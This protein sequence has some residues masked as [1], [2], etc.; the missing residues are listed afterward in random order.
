MINLLLKANFFCTQ[1]QK[2]V[3]IPETK[4]KII[5]LISTIFIQLGQVCQLVVLHKSCIFCVFPVCYCLVIL[6]RWSESC[7]AVCPSFL[8]KLGHHNTNIAVRSWWVTGS[9]SVQYMAGF[10]VA[11]I[12][13][14]VLLFHYPFCICA[15]GVWSHRSS[16]VHGHGGAV[17]FPHRKRVMGSI[18]GIYMFQVLQLPPTIQKRAGHSNAAFPQV[19]LGSARLCPV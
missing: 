1:L 6:S 19:L 12:S 11:H 8:H 16:L 14:F 15:S 13:H 7:P 9:K 17:E 18:S 2:P 4:G 10:D 5:I 3:Y